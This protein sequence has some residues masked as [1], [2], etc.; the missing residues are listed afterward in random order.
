[1]PPRWRPLFEENRPF[2]DLCARWMAGKKTFVE[3]GVQSGGNSLGLLLADPE[4]T[5]L[6][7]DRDSDP[8]AA[9]AVD[10][11]EETAN[12]VA[13]GRFRVIRTDSRTFRKWP[14]V[15]GVIIDGCHEYDW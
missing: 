4:R 11:A 1:M 2:H 7:I 10:F 12:R 13:P 5:G 14:R 3:V 15:D 8:H 9:G 6:G